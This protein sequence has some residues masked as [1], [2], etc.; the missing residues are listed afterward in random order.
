MGCMSMSLWADYK[1]L[2]PSDLGPCALRNYHANEQF[3]GWAPFLDMLWD[4]K[5]APVCS[6]SSY[7]PN[8]LAEWW[9]GVSEKEQPLVSVGVFFTLVAKFAIT[10]VGRFIVHS[11]GFA[12]A[13]CVWFLAVLW[14]LYHIWCLS[15]YIYDMW[16]LYNKSRGTSSGAGPSARPS[17]RPSNA[18][19]FNLFKLFKFKSHVIAFFDTSVEDLRRALQASNDGLA[20]AFKKAVS[21]R[22]RELAKK[23]HSDRHVGNAAHDNTAFQAAN[24][25]K[26]VLLDLVD[27]HSPGELRKVMA[28]VVDAAS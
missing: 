17:A 5:V 25:V 10:E 7:V 9:E 18:E 28:L 19:L 13:F 23:L 8:C 3:A 2:F 4:S 16:C 20:E 26:L 24:E 11:P 15:W 22:F 12:V 27:Q 1:E 6:I 14:L 21:R